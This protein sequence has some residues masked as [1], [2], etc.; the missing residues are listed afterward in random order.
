MRQLINRYIT[1]DILRAIA[2][3]HR[4]GRRLYVGTTNLDAD[5]LVVWNMGAIATSGDANALKLF[6]QVILAS[7]SIS[8]AFPPVLI[9]VVVDGIAYD[10]MHVDGG[11]KAQL[12]LFAATLNLTEFKQKLGILSK[13]NRTRS[14]FV[15]R[16]AEV[17]TEPE[18]VP[19]N[20]TEISERAL[21]SLIKT[22]ALNDLNRIY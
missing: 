21:L 2:K 6:R 11:I 17:G 15:I 16:N 5:R 13:A 4:K 22:Q 18:Q 20:L 9:Q 1:Q 8:G 14:I 12:F 19:R 10:E 7:A 3:A